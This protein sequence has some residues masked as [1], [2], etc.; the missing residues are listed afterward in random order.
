MQMHWLFAEPKLLID[1]GATERAKNHV[2]MLK[3][4]PEVLRNAAAM[5]KDPQPFL[6]GQRVLFSGLNA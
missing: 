5:A 6:E 3:V 1:A 4:Y 2:D